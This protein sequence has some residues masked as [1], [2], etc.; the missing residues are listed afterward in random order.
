VLTS[1][2]ISSLVIDRLCDQA[3]GGDV[4]VPCGC[5]DFAARRGQAPTSILSA[6]FK[7]VVGGLEGIPVEISQAY[8]DQKRVIGGRG[9]QL[10]DIVKHG[11]D[12]LLRNETPLCFA[13][14]NGSKE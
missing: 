5:F 6:L 14:S 2:D 3:R 7:Q 12:Y 13:S 11:A 9:P 4:A 10:S 8:E 1:R